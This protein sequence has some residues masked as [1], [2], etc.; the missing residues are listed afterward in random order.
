MKS[1]HGEFGLRI[2]RTHWRTREEIQFE[3]EAI[4]YLDKQGGKLAKILAKRDGDRVTEIEAQK[5]NACSC[6]AV[7]RQNV[8]PTKNPSMQANLVKQLLNFIG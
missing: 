8:F 5:V 7:V 2:Y 3:L 1:S 4:D 6:D